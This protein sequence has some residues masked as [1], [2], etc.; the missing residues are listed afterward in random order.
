MFVRKVDGVEV[1]GEDVGDDVP[2]AGGDEFAV[3]SKDGV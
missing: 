3:I 1:L 2:E